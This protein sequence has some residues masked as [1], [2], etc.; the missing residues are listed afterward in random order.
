MLDEIAARFRSVAPAADF[1]SLRIVD[2]RYEG[3]AVRRDELEPVVET[4]SVGAMITVAAG[5]G[6]AYAATG[7]LTTAG[8]RAAAEQAANAARATA[9]LALFDASL[10]PR[11][12][13]NGRHASRVERPWSSLS[14]DDRIALVHEACA[15]L[16]VGERVVDRWAALGRTTSDVLLVSSG[17]GRIEQRFDLLRP[18]LAAVA[19]EGSITQRRTHAAE[20]C[21]RQGGLEQLDALGYVERAAALAEEAVALLSAAPCPDEVTDLVLLPGQM[22][23]QIHESI[24]H[25]LELDRI[26]GDE[27]N[28]AG[29]SFVDPSMFGSYRYGSELLD[30]TFDPTR[31]E[32]AASYGFD[33]EGTPAERTYLIRSGVLER[34]LGGA[35]SQARAGVEGVACARSCGWQRP[36]IDRMANLNLEPGASTLAGMIAGVERGV[37]MDVNR[38]WSI[39]DRRNKFQFGCETARRI[40]DGKLGE[41][42]RDPGYRGR[43]ATFWRSLAAVAR[44]DELEV[45]GPANCGKGEPNQ[46]IHV[47]HASPPC[48][49]RGVEV[50]GGG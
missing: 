32:Q 11:V 27:R 43:S 34:P 20:N 10:L 18:G 15:R 23:L 40:V 38:S 6:H 7:D 1:W 39:D 17:G 50:F 12:E 31:P 29:G 16:A 5:G 22:V 46:A 25:P 42:L 13:R 47:G 9:D 28:Y 4:R 14:L 33:D 3:V 26:L 19:N 41:L 37:L 49:F 2:E 45:W 8:L 35:L 24:G 30:V 48:L 36:P 44:D 21:V